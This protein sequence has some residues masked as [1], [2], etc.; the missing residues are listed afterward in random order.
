MLLY[1]RYKIC[2]EK[3]DV[4]HLAGLARIALTEKEVES[5]AKDMTDILGYVSDIE[6]ITGNKEKEKKVGPLF[7]M[8]REDKDP[9]EAGK[10][11]KD[12]LELAP[13]RKGDY[14]HVKKILGETK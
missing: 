14:I 3:K 5:L 7:N 1:V 10:Y 6:E 2:M 12:L 11:T 8:M 4:Q 13:D 9:H